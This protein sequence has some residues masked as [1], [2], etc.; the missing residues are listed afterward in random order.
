M[1]ELTPEQRLTEAAKRIRSAHGLNVV[2]DRY[3][4]S[5]KEIGVLY[6]VD[7]EAGTCTCHD[8]LNFGAETG[9][10]CKHLVALRQYRGEKATGS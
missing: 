6:E 1:R 7:L 8:F 9:I 2:G 5:A 10:A 4:E 3:V